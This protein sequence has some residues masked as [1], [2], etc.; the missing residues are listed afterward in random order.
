MVELKKFFFL[1]ALRLI[2]D[3]EK[4]FQS[5][6]NGKKY[7]QSPFP[8]PPILAKAWDEFILYSENY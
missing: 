8:A 1:V 2:N 3:K 4:K 7:Y 5:E 6:I